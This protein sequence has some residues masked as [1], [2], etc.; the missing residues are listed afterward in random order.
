M[1]KLGKL[2]R[3]VNELMQEAMEAALSQAKVR[4]KDVDG[5]IALPALSEPRFMQAHYLGTKTGLLPHKGV[6][7]RTIDTGGAGPI[8][9]ILEAD[10]LIRTHSCDLVLVVAGDS[11]SSMDSQEFLKYADQGCNDPDNPLPSPVIPNGYDRV[12]NWQLGSYAPHFTREQL[13]MVSVL[14][15]HQASKHP[16]SLSFGKP[17]YGLDNVLESRPIGKVTN[18]LECARRADGAAAVVVASTRF[19]LEHGLENQINPVIIA[20]GEASGPLFPPQVIDE[21][22]FSCEYAS[23][24]AY[25]NMFSA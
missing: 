17:R 12:A 14:M 6:V 11:V 13:G 24:L 18:L 4:L 5:L 3:P 15:N 7:C 22:M 19:I 21:D 16:N 20:G 2:N 9:A 8:S 25:Q 1:T 10:R 23:G